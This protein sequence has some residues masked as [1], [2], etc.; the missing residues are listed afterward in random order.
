MDIDY[1]LTLQDF[2][3]GIDNALTP[4]MEWISLF[5]VTYLIMLPVF[6]YWVL[7]KRSGLY[8]LC[9]YYTAVAVNA[10][11][12]LSVCAYR[13]WIRDQRVLP[14]GDAITTATGYSFPSGHTM[15]AGPIYGGLSVITWKKWK[16]LSAIFL[17]CLLITAFSRNYLG[18][19]TPQD[20]LVGLLLSALSLAGIAKVF[21]VIEK[22]PEWEK[23]FL[24]GGFVLGMAII[25]FIT[26]KPY[27]MDY[28]DGKL[29]VDPQKM[30]NDGYGDPAKLVA[31]CAARAVERKWIRFKP[32]GLKNPKGLAVCALGMIGLWALIAFIGKPLD[33]ALGSHWGHFASNFIIVFY[34]VALVPLALKFTGSR[35]N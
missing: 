23:W 20:V 21:V 6:V 34:C 31:F 5:A 14:A 11:V 9:S 33:A 30:M 12:K 25:G 24:L 13:P 27:P 18:V 19:H 8:V 4:F 32:S 15:T 10:I 28:V 35:E 16:W 22:H 29:L 3:N 26:W 17:L 1:L 7:D 2:R